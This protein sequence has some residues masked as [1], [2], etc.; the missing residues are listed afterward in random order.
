MARPDAILTRIACAAAALM[1]FFVLLGPAGGDI[2]GS[3]I[4]VLFLLH[5]AIARDWRW[6]R[7]RWVQCALALTLFISLRALWA[8]DAISLW[9]A[10]TW[11]RYPVFGAALAFWCLRGEATRK[12][13][14]LVACIAAALLVADTLVQYVFH[15]DLTGRPRI[16]Y[17]SIV[18]L[19]GPYKSPHVGSV[20]L[21]LIFPALLT[22]RFWPGVVLG[23]AATIA[24]YL[25]GERMPL[26]LLLLGFLLSFLLLPRARAMLAAVLLTAV[27]GAAALTL[28]QPVLHTRHIDDTRQQ[29][30]GG[31]WQSAYG[32]VWHSAL[33]I[34][35]AHPLAGVG[36]EEF[37]RICPDPAYGETTPRALH[38]RCPQHPHNIYLQWFA[39]NGIVGLGLYCGML[40][41][42]IGT[43]ARRSFVWSNEPLATALVVTLLV[44]LWPLAVGTNLFSSWSAMT[45]WLV[46][47]WLL[48][49]LAAGES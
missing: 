4:A 22:R 45:L 21:A 41:C 3:F 17:G 13:L 2:A 7:E 49:L 40:A 12:R 6:T 23:V 15:V 35:E 33:A 16:D 38:F 25:S 26:L 27:L 34:A 10:A 46:A 36:S 31:L 24:I 19:T 48:A 42:W 11:L 44:R 20:I 9:R 32:Q 1:P 39:E 37:S 18:R 29:F 14:F 47:G 30:A 5:S 43:V 28:T 8:P